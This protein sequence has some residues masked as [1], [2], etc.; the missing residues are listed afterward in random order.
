MIVNKSKAYL[1]DNYGRQF[2]YLRLSIT[3]SC[4]FR[5]QY[6]LPNGYI[7]KNK[8]FLTLEEIRRLVNAFAMLGVQSVRLSGG[9][10]TL[11]DDLSD[12]AKTIANIPGINNVSL[13]TNG[14][15][16]FEYVK[17][18]H[19]SGISNI[20]ISVDSLNPDNFCKITGHDCLNKVLA[21][22]NV[23]LQSNFNQIKINTVLLNNINTEE[24]PTF[25]AWTKNNPI[26]VRFIELMQ[27]G[28]NTNYF[29]KYHISPGEVVQNLLENTGWQLKSSKNIEQGPAIEYF[30]P[31][32]KG[33][34]GIIAPYSHNFCKSCNR[35]RVSSL[36]ILHLCLFDSFGYSLRHLL[37]SDEQM[38]ELKEFIL[39]KLF[40]KQASH[41][42][43]SNSQV[44]NS[45]FATIG[46]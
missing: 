46:G 17:E 11:R 35:L 6:C 22:I 16:L 42:H 1:K 43:Y 21:G 30:N 3:D 15:R 5:C 32:Y 39:N 2:N 20:N 24:I 34:I 37:Q 12:I 31:N 9:E 23:A 44:K 28:C 38:T 7:S 26:C 19:Q 14:Y 27:T 41:Y 18:L 10:P 8:N 33:T 45:S 36:G 13:T 4:N 25:I 29:R 40:F